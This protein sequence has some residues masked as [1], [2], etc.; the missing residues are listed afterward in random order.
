MVLETKIRPNWKFRTDLEIDAECWQC[1]T[2]T[3]QHFWVYDTSTFSIGISK[4]KKCG[5]EMIEKICSECWSPIDLP[6]DGMWRTGGKCRDC[7][8]EAIKKKSDSY[9]EAVI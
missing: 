9:K 6:K 3:S 4:C 8:E 1:K 2:T 5:L 7:Y